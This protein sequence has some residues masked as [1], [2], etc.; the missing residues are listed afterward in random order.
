MLISPVQIPDFVNVIYTLGL[1]PIYVKIDKNSHSMNLDDLQNQITS[2]TKVI[3]VTH[4]HGVIGEI[5][6]IKKLCEDRSIFLIEDISHAYGSI[7]NNKL[8]GTYGHAAVGSLSP[9]KIVSSVGG[10]FL[11]LN[12]DDKFNKVKKLKKI[13]LIKPKKIILYRIIFFQLLVSIVTSRIIFNN[14]TYYLFS[15]LNKIN[16]NMYSDFKW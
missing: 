10:G 2:R 11:L 4:Y 3:L 13:D 6:V 12:D 7:L 1:K 9:G 16:K 5:E 14:I 8:A 15:I